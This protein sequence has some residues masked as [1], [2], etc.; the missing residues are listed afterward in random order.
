MGYLMQSGMM[1]FSSLFWNVLVV[2]P[3]VPQGILKLLK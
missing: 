3:S 1:G 2:F